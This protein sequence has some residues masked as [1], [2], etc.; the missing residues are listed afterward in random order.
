MPFEGSF[1]KKKEEGETARSP[2]NITTTGCC[3]CWCSNKFVF[4]CLPSFFVLLFSF[5]LFL[6]SIPKSNNKRIRRTTTKQTT[7]KQTNNKNSSHQKKHTPTITI[8]VLMIIPQITHNNVHTTFVWKRI[9]SLPT[10]KSFRFFFCLLHTLFFIHCWEMSFFLPLS[11]FFSLSFSYLI[12]EGGG[13]G[14]KRPKEKQNTFFPRKT[15]SFLKQNDNKRN[16]NKNAHTLRSSHNTNKKK[17]PFFFSFL[18][19]IFFLTGFAFLLACL[20]K[21]KKKKKKKREKR[22]KD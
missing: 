4:S 11:H 19:S 15:W 5:F 7:K 18:L 16:P 10:K 22:E 2:H 14:K 21:K 9:G 12:R 20:R 1:Q 17:K 13:E 3:C 6:R 8:F